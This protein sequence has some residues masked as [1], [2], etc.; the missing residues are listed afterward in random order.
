MIRSIEIGRIGLSREKFSQK[1]GLKMDALIAIEERLSAKNFNKGK[2]LK[3]E[4]IQQLIEYAMH[5]PSA[6][7]LQHT[8]FLVVTDNEAKK[9]LQQIAKGQEKV[10]EASATFVILSDLMA[11]EV[12][13]YIANKGVEKGIYNSEV[14]E[15]IVKTA[16]SIY[17]ENP[18]ISRDEAIRSASFA[19]MNLMTAATAMGM[20]SCPMGGFDREALKEQFMIDDRY[21]PVMLVSVGFSPNT[22]QK[23]KPRLSPQEVAIVDA[24]PGTKAIWPELIST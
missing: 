7:N 20:S 19:A 5:A 10:M 4:Q 6:C 3:N 17:A 24:R 13:D 11:H 8:R 18:Q 12:I 14:S 21:L 16:L 23:K 2:L 9:V 22:K 1:R 15:T